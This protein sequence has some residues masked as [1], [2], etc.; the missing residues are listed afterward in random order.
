MNAAESWVL[1]FDASCARCRGISA[2]VAQVCDGKLDV[3]PLRHPDVEQWRAQALG[4]EAPWAPTLLAV[5]PDRVRAWTGAGMAVPLV[6]RL[7]IR[8]TMRLLRALGSMPS[9]QGEAASSNVMGRKGF[10]KLGAGLAAA[11][12]LVLAGKTPAAAA[13][14]GGSECEKAGAWVE[15]NKH[16]LPQDYAGFTAH[17][18]SYRRAIYAELPAAVRS[19]LWIAHFDRYQASHPNLTASQSKLLTQARRVAADPGGWTKERLAELRESAVAAFG[20]AEAGAI[21]ATLGTD[22]E[23]SSPQG[24]PGCGCCIWD[25][26]C[27]GGSCVGTIPPN[28]RESSSGCGTLWMSPCNGLC[29]D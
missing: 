3:L 1:A 14:T 11:A 22:P 16:R 18:M 19:K 25:V 4:A 6:R 9:G 2:V 26:Y 15:A 23:R 10:L 7:G 29:Y 24:L 5:S 21:L 8:S 27:G 20:L 13:T 28:C 17:S 12:G